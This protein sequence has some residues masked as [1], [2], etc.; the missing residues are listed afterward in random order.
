M[1]GAISRYMT[2]GQAA[3]QIPGAEPKE[4]PMGAP[5]DVT[6][7]AAASCSGREDVRSRPATADGDLVAAARAGD[8]DAW[9]QLY[10]GVHRRLRGYV[11]RRVG[12]EHVEDVM[13]ET[14]TRAVARLDRFD[15]GPAGF[16][17]WVFGIARRVVFEHNRRVDTARRRSH[18]VAATV[19]TMGAGDVEPGDDLVLAD[20]H[21]RVRQL[22]ARLSPAERELLELR[23]VAGLSA[24]DV[25]R[26][27]GKRPG[28]V[29]TAQ[30]RALANLRRLLEEDER[31]AADD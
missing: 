10:R 16:D 12:G 13:S 2:E 28:A 4:I 29:R 25:A 24:E 1:G 6:N 27:L 17:G 3:L 31:Q 8:Q 18:D 23:V 14:M 11:S 22:F 21:A 26:V 9:E 30:S 15:L 7:A 19:D 20:E 5:D